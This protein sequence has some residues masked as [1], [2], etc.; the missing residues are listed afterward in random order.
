MAGNQ[1]DEVTALKSELTKTKCSLFIAVRNTTILPKGLLLGKDEKEI[2][3]MTLATIEEMENAVDFK[4][5]E[6]MIKLGEEAQNNGNAGKR[7]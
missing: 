3:R 5:I 6:K 7:N 2:S 4:A 1:I